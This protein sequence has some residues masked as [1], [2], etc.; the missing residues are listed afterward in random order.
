M[1]G[2]PIV[3]QMV[4]EQPLGHA[5]EQTLW[6]EGKPLVRW[7]PRLHACARGILLA[8]HFP[9][10]GNLALWTWSESTQGGE[11][12][13]GVLL[14]VRRRLSESALLL[15][16][17]PSEQAPPLA[18]V[19]A[20]GLWMEQLVA[21][22]DR[23]LSRFV[24]LTL[25][26]PMVH[27]WAGH[28]AAVPRVDDEVDFDIAGTVLV[29][30]KA[31]AGH[32]VVLEDVRGLVIGKMRSDRSGRFRFSRLVPGRYRL[33]GVSERVDFPVTG[34]AVEVKGASVENL[35]LKSS[36]SVA[37]RRAPTGPPVEDVVAKE[38]ATIDPPSRPA[39]DTPDRNNGTAKRVWAVVGCVALAMLVL[40]QG[41]LR[42]GR[43]RQPEVMAGAVNAAPDEVGTLRD[44]GTPTASVAGDVAPHLPNVP[45]PTGVVRTQPS[46]PSGPGQKDGAGDREGL[47]DRDPQADPGRRTEAAAVEPEGASFQSRQSSVALPQSSLPGFAAGFGPG[48]GSSLPGGVSTVPGSPAGL[49]GAGAGPPPSS[50]GAPGSAALTGGSGPPG[51][52]ASRLNPSVGSPG[53]GAEAPPPA[54]AP[55]GTD[56][57]L[58]AEK[59]LT[60]ETPHAL[61]RPVKTGAPPDSDRQAD[62]PP[63]A[64]APAAAPPPSTGQTPATVDDTADGRL[65]RERAAG[66]DRKRNEGARPGERIATNLPSGASAPAGSPLTLGDGRSGIV[67]SVVRIVISPGR[68]QLVRDQIVETFPQP[69]GKSG[70]TTQGA[71]E[72]R[73]AGLAARPSELEAMTLWLGLSVRSPRS[74]AWVGVE[75]GS[76]DSSFS[77]R[78]NELGWPG[79][80]SP[81]Q[82][83]TWSSDA[84][85]EVRLQL[86]PAGEFEVA[87]RPD[88]EVSLWWAAPRVERS[89]RELASSHRS[90]GTPLGGGEAP[91][92]PLG[93]APRY[94]WLR[95]ETPLEPCL[96]KDRWGDDGT[97]WQ[98]ASI[99]IGSISSRGERMALVDDVTGWAWVIPVQVS[100]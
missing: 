32:E 100:R 65:G 10:A 9:G 83:A 70:R 36:A 68:V 11:V 77:V 47:R 64:D 98:Q 39:Q 31:D 25:H 96:R 90:A 21:Q 80:A 46:Q 53:A 42:R 40:W 82:G 28:V 75:S 38:E 97:T 71:R 72:A 99:P 43:S 81:G 73:A 69:I 55:P 12:N 89:A 76:S 78:G 20:Y 79:T 6:A 60:P 49:P 94:R 62:V 16:E 44:P 54:P 24:C 50:G 4:A 61:I 58:A 7:W 93:M 66:A 37:G 57:G 2:P 8:P 33:R 29:M 92:L 51:A 23:D 18:V 56:A 74:G 5:R 84:G 41:W 45:R 13:S 95:M 30:G 48:S 85:V 14:T 3:R 26:G 34:L 67:P 91:P 63:A 88:V 87:S 15:R 17:E 27:S 1:S 35:E 52:L 86:G 59:N 22:S 19:E